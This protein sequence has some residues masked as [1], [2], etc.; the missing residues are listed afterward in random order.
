MSTELD[1]PRRLLEKLGDTTEAI[2]F[3][4]LFALSDLGGDAWV[5]FQTTWDTLPASQH[6]RLL[7]ALAELAEASF[8]V[9]FDAIFRYCLNNPDAEVRATAIDGLWENE[10]IALIG[11]LLSMLR[12][13]PSARVRA[14]AATGLGRFVLAGELEKLEPPV[15]ARILTEL[16][17]AIHLLGE[18]IEVRRR[19]LESAAYACRPDVFEALQMAYFDDDHSMR[20]SAIVG[21]GRSCDDRWKDFV[22]TELES[23]SPAMRYEAALACGELTLRPAVPILARLI[24][25][26]DGQVRDASI[27][28]LGQIGGAQ[29]RDVL[30]DAY[31]E[32][33]DETRT[34][35]DDALAEQALAEGDLDFPMV[36][37][38]EELDDAFLDG[39]LYTLW[40]A[41]EEDIDRLSMDDQEPQDGQ[42]DKDW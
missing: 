40:A 26:A 37:I 7:H 2:P 20:L 28:A 1:D 10:E 23:T 30:L 3:S 36:E 17:T 38:V 41:D 42:A 6:R 24:D 9:N 25:D 18:S 35:L 34:A 11:P 32:A 12:S 21:M 27:W 8:Q 19:A 29:A 13:D 31:D 22:L 4:Q 16:L 15:Q 14:A 33:D 39:D 5:E